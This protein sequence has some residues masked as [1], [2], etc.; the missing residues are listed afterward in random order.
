M[1]A[2]LPSNAEPPKAELAYHDPKRAP[3]LARLERLVGHP[4]DPAKVRAAIGTFE[5]APVQ[6]LPPTALAG[7]PA[8]GASRA[9]RRDSSRTRAE[10]F[11]ALREPALE[12]DPVGALLPGSP[13]RTHGRKLT[14]LDITSGLPDDSRDEDQRARAVVERQRQ[15]RV[16]AA[17][18][19]LQDHPEAREVVM[20]DQSRLRMFCARFGVTPQ[21]LCPHAETDGARIVHPG[22]PRDGMCG[23]C[24]GRHGWKPVHVDDPVDVL[25]GPHDWRAE[26]EARASAV[27]P[28]SEAW[29]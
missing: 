21:D 7:L 23:W 26:V 4:V 5:V 14:L 28:G 17:R 2:A 6:E 19:A 25:S 24:A 11:I 20:R 16:K 22:S 27:L 12:D 15:G 8:T 13:A 3:T 18:A 1:S 10:A 9:P 29:G